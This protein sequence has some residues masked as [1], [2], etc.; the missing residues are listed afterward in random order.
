MVS[1]EY[2]PPNLA[3]LALEYY[4][5]EV[6]LHFETELRR[7]GQDNGNMIFDKIIPISKYK[8]LEYGI[9]TTTDFITFGSGENTIDIENIL[10]IIKI[11]DDPEQITAFK[12]LSFTKKI[13]DDEIYYEISSVNNF[14]ES[15]E[16]SIRN[17]R[18]NM[19]LVVSNEEVDP[20]VRMIILKIREFYDLYRM[21]YFKTDN[22]DIQN[23]LENPDVDA[24]TFET[25]RYSGMS[26]SIYN[27]VINNFI[28]LP[29]PPI[30]S[31]LYDKYIEA[32]EAVEEH[33]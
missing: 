6:I 13:K 22:K 15:I 32:R 20:K 10:D 5:P 30:G 17:F 29:S 8:E 11:I 12:K 9:I 24:F 3:N 31:K 18:I 21:N 28:K 26:D 14:I 19:G 33:L 25:D 1:I 2:L 27:N 23:W 7:A 4:D 16:D